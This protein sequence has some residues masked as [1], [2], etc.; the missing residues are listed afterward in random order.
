MAFAL[1]ARRTPMDAAAVA[2][3]HFILRFAFGTSVGLTIGEAFGW[4]PTFFGPLIAGVIL[5]NLP[6]ALPP[7]AGVAIVLMQAIG[8]YGAYSLSALLHDVPIV[9]FGLIAILILVSFANL[10]HGRGFL[11]LLIVLISFST[12]P[13]LTMISPEQAAALP[14][15]FSRS[16]AL[17]VLLVWTMHLLWPKVAAAAPPVPPAV[18]EAPIAMAIA[19]TAI[20][21]PLMLVYLM[22]G[23][24]DALPVLITTVML[25]INFD[26]K[27]SAIQGAGMMLG[28]FIGGLMAYGAFVVLSVA[29]TL[30]MLELI[31]LL[32]AMVFAGRMARG[33]SARAVGLI[34]FNQF[35][36]M[37]GLAMMPGKSTAGLWINRLF[38]F[39][40]AFAFAV[41]M[42][43]VLWPL[44]ARR[45][46]GAAR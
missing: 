15:A 5:V 44:I 2:R 32:V 16:T 30:P 11:P 45:R 7:K 4:Y 41:G 46:R 23:L 29:P 37:F 9:L 43:T 36:V 34:T 33:G 3:L 19:G 24:T 14:F 8:A 21:L 40:L 18:A 42:M 13:V 12:I 6:A 28:N 10:A 27:R 38:Q 22:Y 1:S 26:P 20:V 39:G 25:V 35:M 17:A 31:T